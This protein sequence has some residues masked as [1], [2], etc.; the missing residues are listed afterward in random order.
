[1]YKQQY[2]PP[3]FEQLGQYSQC[4]RLARMTRPVCVSPPVHYSTCD[5]SCDYRQYPLLNLQHM[6]V[7]KGYHRIGNAY[8]L[9]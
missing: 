6:R 5:T 9:R 3:Y 7:S 4:G 8:N 1:M 2:L